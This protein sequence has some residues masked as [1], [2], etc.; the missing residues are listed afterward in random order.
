M[1]TYKTIDEFLTRF[2]KVKPNGKNS[3]QALC[4]AHEDKNPSLTITIKD[5]KILLH[6]HAGCTT[7]AILTSLNLTMADLFLDDHHTH[8]APSAKPTQGIGKLVKVYKYE[9]ADRKPLFEVC[10]YEPKT[11]RQ[12]HYVNGNPVWGLADIQPV[13]YRLP[14]VLTAMAD[15]TTIY[16]VEGEKDVDTLGEWGLIGTCNPMGAGKWHP[17]YTEA[18]TGA[19]VVIIPDNDEAGRNHAKQVINALAGKAA[20]IKIVV[21]TG[22]SIKDVTDFFNNGGDRDTLE[23]LVSKTREYKIIKRISEIGGNGIMSMKFEPIKWVI[24]DM[25]PEGSALLAGRPKTGKSRMALNLALAVATG[26]KALN[27]IPVQQGEVY[28]MSLE[29]SARRIKEHIDEAFMN[30]PPDISNITFR[31]SFNPG[32]N[33]LQVLETWLHNHQSARLVVIDTLQKIRP[34]VDSF[35]RGLYDQDYEAVAPYTELASRYNVSIIIIHHLN[36]RL[37]TDD[38]M[39][40]ISGTTGL[41]GA[42]DM[43]IVL[44]RTR[45][46]VTGTMHI[47]GRDIEDK[48]IAVDFTGGNWSWLGDANKVKLS[49]EREEIIDYLTRC[50]DQTPKQIADGI[51][52][53]RGSIRFLLG[54]L[55][56]QDLLIN[57]E[58]KYSVK[59]LTDPYSTNTTNS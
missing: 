21:L 25:L 59:P 43:T 23:A 34:K 45:G 11:F 16:I 44:K 18:L 17:Q 56:A 26:G 54:K 35:T 2:N 39:E 19:N 50:P 15:G 33:P 30:E 36:K 6:C 32:E 53:P 46:E 14:D 31:F 20:S 28:Y 8:D 40:G 58:G 7:E 49:Q 42:V 51:D 52:K 24:P 29:D 5:K 4:P 13:I 37:P 38:P 22:D 55:L 27:K 10:R 3:Y 57:V 9:T 48:E 47:Y 12:R 41:T 1:A